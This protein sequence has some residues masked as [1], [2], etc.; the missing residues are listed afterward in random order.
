M[1]TKHSVITG[2]GNH[3]I[4][5]QCS[6]PSKSNNLAMRDKRGNRRTCETML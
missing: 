2:T 4:A 1:Y 3:I 5:R 6:Q